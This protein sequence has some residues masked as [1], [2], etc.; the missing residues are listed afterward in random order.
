MQ[1][2]VLCGSEQDVM[3]W[4]AAAALKEEVLAMEKG[5]ETVIGSGGTRLSGGQAQRLA[6]AR[7]LAHPR[8]VLVLESAHPS[9]L[10]AYRGF[11]G[12]APFGKVNAFL[13]NNGAAEIEWRLPANATHG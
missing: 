7:T 3:P 10:S 8:P 4:L 9:P 5:T 1:N 6:L 12:S 13:K 2:N 11:F